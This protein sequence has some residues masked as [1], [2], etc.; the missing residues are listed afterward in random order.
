MKT[1]R[2]MIAALLV[3]CLALG[4]AACGT[5]SAPAA[6]EE[7]AA[8]ETAA[9]SEAAADDRIIVI[10]QSNDISSLDPQ[11]HNEL[12]SGNVT[13][14]IY[15]TLIRIT[16]DNEF[17]PGL[18]ESWEFEDNSVTFH[19]RQGVK[20]HDGSELTA[21][22]VAYT[23]DRVNASG[24]TQHLLTMITGTEIVD[25]YTI[26]FSLT[27]Q[28]A[29]LMSSLSH[30]GTGIVSK[31]YTEALEADGKT[32]SDAPCGTGPYKFD[33]W[34]VGTECQLVAFE[35]YY[36]ENYA[37][38]NAG[39]RYRYIAEDN[40][41]VIALETG[42]IDI[43]VQVPTTAI[44]ELQ[45]DENINVIMYTSADLNYMSPN[46]SKAPFDNELL[47]RAVSYCID[48]DSMIQVQCSGYAKPNYAPIGLAAIGYSD[49]A[50]KY[51]YNLEKAKECL[52]EAG[53]P[54]GFDFTISCWGE[55]NAKSAQVLQA[56]CKQV[57]INVSIEILDNAGMTSKCGG[58][59]HDVGMDNW[60]A[61]SEPDNTFRPWF[62]RSGIGQGG[63]M[64]CCYE[65]DEIEAL[66]EKAASTN[67]QA[68]R[69]TYYSEINNFVSEHSIVWPLFSRDG[70]VAT[71]SNVQG[72]VIPGTNQPEFQGV[73]I[74]G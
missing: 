54:D 7:P 23:V 6:T 9:D 35:D 45:A 65:G 27:D 22:D 19:L 62:L 58:A 1:T 40:S 12:T 69:Q 8:T 31:A 44:E 42:E 71:R 3:L 60:T 33:Y 55:Q 43:M 48:R 14:M 50:V 41:R 30:Q 13:R 38:K 24:F 28:S 66:V 73:T 56:A 63:Y 72:L 57:G 49:P 10:A 36:D 39:L 37:A 18:A 61:N 11:G 70:V 16:P 68:E 17:V 46:C 29:A 64:W 51:E 26:K 34:T 47:R 15:D 2:K 74:T 32:L 20:F 59:Q 4:L 5:S 52:E 21:Q 25:D 67:D 53:Y